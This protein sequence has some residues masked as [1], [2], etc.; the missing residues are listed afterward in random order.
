MHNVRRQGVFTLSLDCEGQWGMADNRPFVESGVIN[1]RSLK[2]AYTFL[3]NVLDECGLIA[4]AAFV[5]SFAVGE[6]IVRENLGPLEQ[7]ATLNPRWFAS[8]MTALKTKAFG[9]WN[10]REFYRAMSAAGFEM[11]WHGA[12]HLPLTSATSAQSVALELELASR[13]F[14]ALNHTPRT[15][16]FPRNLI[17]HL[18]QLRQFGFENYRDGLAQGKSG[19][20]TNLLREFVPFARCDQTPPRRQGGWRVA[21]PGAFLNWPSGGRALVPV[22]LTVIRWKAM[23]RD[24]A[25][26]GGDVHMW[27]HPHNLITAPSMQTS[28]AEIIRFAGELVKTGHLKNLTIAGSLD[29]ATRAE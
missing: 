8:M 6:E 1:D 2:A 28:F 29:D 17:G 14:A 15:I 23:L 24:A 11:A 7:L 16:V 12:T 25:D 20:V 18:D 10:G 19:R 26:H 13:H 21:R 27:F 9:G 22:A 3:L 5:S 4:T